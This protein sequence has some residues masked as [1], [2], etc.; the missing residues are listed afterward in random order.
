M[1]VGLLVLRHD[2]IH[3]FRYRSRNAPD[4]PQL[5]FL[6]AAGTHDNR[7]AL[8]DGADVRLSI[9]LY[10]VEDAAAESVG[11]LPERLEAGISLG[12]PV[13]RATAHLHL[14]AH[15]RDGHAALLHGFLDSESVHVLNG[16]G[17]AAKIVLFPYTCTI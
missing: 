5:D 9:I 14:P 2:G 15:F 16:F 4:N 17:D 11:Y 1:V 8:H 10:E 6:T 12:E 7:G 3:V 13:E